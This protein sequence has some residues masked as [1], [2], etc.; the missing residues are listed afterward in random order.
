MLSFVE[1][2]HRTNFQNNLG[3]DIIISR[4]DPRSQILPSSLKINP[5]CLHLSY[6]PLP[7]TTA[8]SRRWQ[9]QD[10]GRWAQMTTNL[11]SGGCATALAGQQQCDARMAALLG[12]EGG[13]GHAAVFVGWWQ[14]VHGSEGCQRW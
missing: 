11:G 6:P 10:G 8:P 3:V 9:Q 7:P 1:M 2:Q 5:P 14:G 12:Q 13:G 4:Y